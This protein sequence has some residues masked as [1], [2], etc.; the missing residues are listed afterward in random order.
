VGVLGPNGAGKTSLL[1]AIS[2]L[3][4]PASGTIRLD[5]A[6][7]VGKPAYRIARLG[8]AHVPEGRAILA[9]LTVEENLLMGGYLAS[10][11]ELG[12]RLAA[13][14]E[15]FP[16]LRARLKVHA[17]LLSGGEQQMLAI[18]RGMMSGPRL[19]VI[20]VSTGMSLLLAE[21]NASLALDVTQRTYVLVQG[22]VALSRPSADIGPDLMDS[23]LD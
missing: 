7:L 14:L 4:R 13:M 22:E 21:Q 19:L 23:Y 20:V 18:A 10:R 1:R 17:G 2:G 8:L 16:S 6:N 11:R 9:P 5:G 15:L 3:V 12:D